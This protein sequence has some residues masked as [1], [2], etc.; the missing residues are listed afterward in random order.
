MK[1]DMLGGLRLPKVL[2]NTTDMF[3]KYNIYTG[4]FGHWDEV[5][6]DMKSVVWKKDESVPKLCVEKLQL[7]G[8][9]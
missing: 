3:S 7:S 5:V 4:T 8:G 6:H 9:K 1:A 2:K